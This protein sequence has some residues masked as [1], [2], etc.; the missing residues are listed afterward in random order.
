MIRIFGDY[1]LTVDG[2][3][4]CSYVVGKRTLSGTDTILRKSARYYPS[5][6]IATAETAELAQSVFV[7]RE[8]NEEKLL[9][10]K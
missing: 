4:G 7:E 5:L 1:F 9:K 6:A 10:C 8:S 2:K 3:N